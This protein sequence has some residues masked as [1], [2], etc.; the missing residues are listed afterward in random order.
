MVMKTRRSRATLFGLAATLGAG[1]LAG[2]SGSSGAERKPDDKITVWSQ[3]NLAPRMAATKKVVER[4]EKETGV[5]V[6]LVGVDEAQL[7]QLI[8]SAAAAG[9]LPDVIGAV[10]MGQVWQMY[11]SGLL[12]TE[13]AGKIV[14]D[15]GTGTFNANA[16]SLTED[17]GTTLAVPSDA[18]LQLLVYRKDLFAKA[19]LDAPDSYASALKAAKTLDKGGVDGISLATDPSDVFTQQSFEDLALANGCQ[20][21]DDDGEPALDS[22]ACRTAF[23][24]YSELGGEHGAPGTQTVDST[25]STYFSGKSSMMVWS[26]FLLDELAGLRS[27]ALPSCAECQ[28]DPGFLARNTG[29]VTSLQGPDSEEPAQ[30]GEITSWAVTKT[31]ET[32]ASAKFIEYMMGKGYEDWFGMAPEGKIPVRTGTT[33]DPGSFQKAWRASVMG[34]DRRESMQKAYPS[35]LLDRLVAGVGDMKRWG[36]TQGQ[37]TLVGATNGELPVAKA[38]GAMT[39]GQSSPDEAAKEANDEVAALQKSLQ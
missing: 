2:C 22:A 19:G 28:D 10:P 31:A 29:I 12:N 23:A 4:F 6:D 18:W 17:A 16:L 20:L 33:T 8:M 27:D 13:V 15:L 5:Q 24:T 34:V 37:G 1:L 38:I 11:G 30:F 36:L 39:S 25:R 32:G 7:P 14:D 26:S 21:V 9:D 35:E 3:E